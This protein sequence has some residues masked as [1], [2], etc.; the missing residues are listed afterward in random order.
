M[1]CPVCGHEM[2]WTYIGSYP[3]P[4]MWKCWACGYEG[5]SS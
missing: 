3:V 2:I 1:N 4:C 5:E